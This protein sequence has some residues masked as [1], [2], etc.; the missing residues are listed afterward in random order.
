MQVAEAAVDGVVAVVEEVEEA[1]VA[2]IG[3]V[4]PLEG[5][6]TIPQI[7]KRILG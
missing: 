1:G 5:R 2:I 7:G 3:E 4:R 6:T